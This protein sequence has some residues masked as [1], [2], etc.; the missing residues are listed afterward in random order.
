M[1]RASYDSQGLRSGV[2]LTDGET[3]R[4][5]AEPRMGGPV[6]AFRRCWRTKPK[7]VITPDESA[8]QGYPNDPPVPPT[9]PRRLRW[10]TGPWRTKL[11]VCLVVTFTKF[12]F[13]GDRLDC[14][15]FRH[16]PRNWIPKRSAILP[17]FSHYPR[18]LCVEQGRR[19]T[20]AKH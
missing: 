6:A 13:F 20:R 11:R 5:T 7:T 10:P 17:D 19:K 4:Q 16:Q 15:L 18:H 12:L 3:S 14:H 1:I 8:A 2:I 9:C